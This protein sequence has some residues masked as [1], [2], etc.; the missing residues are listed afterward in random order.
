[1][2]THETSQELVDHYL[3]NLRNQLFPVPLS[4]RHEF[5]NEITE[6]VAEGRANLEPGDIEGLRTLL[7]H[8]GSPSELAREV[9]EG[10][11]DQKRQMSLTSR[12]RTML[13]PA[14]ALFVAALVVASLLWWTHYQPLRPAPLSQSS[15]SITNSDGKFVPAVNAATSDL[16]GEAPIWDLPKGVATIHIIVSIENA[17][18]L[19]IKIT[20]V[21]SPLRGWTGLGPA[22]VAFGRPN[23]APARPFRPFTVGGN[24]SW[25]VSLALPVRCIASSGYAG[26]TAELSRVLISTSFFGVPHQTWIN[27]WPLTIVFAKSC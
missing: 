19:P 23:G 22:R 6:H 2:T 26:M 17:G 12:A 10:Q 14:L 13:G 21:Q 18:N 24:Q 9:I 7:S 20:G 25:Q 11:R 3:T 15:P 27:V 1:M 4:A 16:P 8:I 5:M